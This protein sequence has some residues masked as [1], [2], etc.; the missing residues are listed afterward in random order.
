M[1]DVVGMHEHESFD[2]RADATQEVAE[3]AGGASRNNHLW[4]PF[5]L[6]DECEPMLGD[7]D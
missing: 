1:C 5:L 7:F 2:A 3:G 6:D 4:G